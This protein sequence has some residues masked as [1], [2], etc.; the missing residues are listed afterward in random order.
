MPYL[1]RPTH[2]AQQQ[3]G[4]FWG[5]IFTRAKSSGEQDLLTG[6]RC[7]CCRRKSKTFLTSGHSKRSG[8]PAGFRGKGLH[9]VSPARDCDF[10]PLFVAFDFL[11]PLPA[12]SIVPACCSHNG[13]S[14]RI[15]SCSSAITQAAVPALEALCRPYAIFASRARF[16]RGC[17]VPLLPRCL[18][19]GCF[20]LVSSWR[21]R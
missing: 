1:L 12:G 5:G 18:L 14:L 11:G 21:R 2:S 8:G 10:A 17:W 20:G 13:L 19:P 15:V 6:F 7:M 4:I 16:A 3:A 9:L